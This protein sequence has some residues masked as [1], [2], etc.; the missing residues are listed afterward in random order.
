[1]LTKMTIKGKR[2]GYRN[3]SFENPRETDRRTWIKVQFVKSKT[4]DNWWFLY[5]IE[6]SNETKPIGW[7]YVDQIDKLEIV[8]GLSRDL[9]DGMVKEINLIYLRAVTKYHPLFNPDPQGFK[10]KYG[11]KGIHSGDALPD[12]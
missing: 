9:Y 3:P 8:S 11:G 1:M 7:F 4:K 5:D 2:S 10:K 6:D 12:K